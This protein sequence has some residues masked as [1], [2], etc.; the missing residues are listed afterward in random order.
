MQPISVH[1]FYILWLCWIYGS[2]LAG[3]CWNL[4]GFTYRVSCHLQRVKIWLP[5]CWF[6]CL[7]FLCIVWLLRLRL[8]ILCWVR[9]VRVDIPVV[10]LT[11]EGNS[12]GWWYYCWVFHKWFSW[13]WG[14]ILISLLSWGFLS[15]NKDVFWYFIK[16]DALPAS[17]NMT[18][19]YCSCPFFY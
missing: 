3:F 12:S 18:G 10:F 8:P 16:K 19:S 2:V 13:S 5:P 9:V 11:L 17:F 7:L 14:M 6:G 15:R 1:W 4:L